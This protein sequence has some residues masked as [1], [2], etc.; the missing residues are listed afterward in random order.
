MLIV[1][2]MAVCLLVLALWCRPQSATTTYLKPPEEI[3]V[4]DAVFL[5]SVRLIATDPAAAIYQRHRV[6]GTQ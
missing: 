6:P 3:P 2:L 4:K 1:G 5:K